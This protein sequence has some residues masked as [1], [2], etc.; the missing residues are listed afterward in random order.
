MQE[1]NGELT[2]AVYA[3]PLVSGFK[4]S[5]LPDDVRAKLVSAFTVAQDHLAGV[6][7]SREEA[8][9]KAVAEK[10]KAQNEQREKQ[11]V[12]REQMRA[13]LA[14][15]KSERTKIDAAVAR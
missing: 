9:Q 13:Q 2:I 4:L 15:E 12:E 8:A 5:E 11:R 1:R 6:Q 14:R 3:H 7:K 10:R